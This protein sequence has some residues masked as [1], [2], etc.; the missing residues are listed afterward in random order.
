MRTWLEAR[1]VRSLHNQA[2]PCLQKQQ[3][4]CSVVH[5]PHH[6]AVTKAN[7]SSENSM[8]SGS[9][10][11]KMLNKAA[12][13]AAPAFTGDGSDFVYSKA[14]GQASNAAFRRMYGG[15]FSYRY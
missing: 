6:S 9:L 12:A 8:Y 14:V 4:S 5:G 3:A 1:E 13:V 11:V 15:K 10:L 2:F 7:A